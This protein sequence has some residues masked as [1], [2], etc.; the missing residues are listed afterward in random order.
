VQKKQD[1]L[2]RA[3]ETLKKTGVA[4]LFYTPGNDLIGKDHEG[5]VDGIHPNDIGMIRI[6]EALHPVVE[7]I[8]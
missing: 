3:F 4:K 8:L 2:K 7:K 1:E 5:T 6:A